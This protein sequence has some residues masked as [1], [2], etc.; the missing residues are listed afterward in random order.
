MGEIDYDDWLEEKSRVSGF[1]DLEEYVKE[2]IY[3]TELG[4]TDED[5]LRLYEIN[6][7][8]NSIVFHWYG[9]LKEIERIDE[10]TESTGFGQENIER[11][12][13]LKEELA[14]WAEELDIGW[15]FT[16]CNLR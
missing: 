5:G 7:N 15:K 10:I 13:V 4:F 8:T 6:Y 9:Q 1:D 14:D 3:E 11:D 2:A 16:I 12:N